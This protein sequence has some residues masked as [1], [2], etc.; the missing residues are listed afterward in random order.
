MDI[1]EELCIYYGQKLWF[2]PAGALTKI[3]VSEV[4]DGWGGL[5][6]VDLDG[7]VGASPTNPYVEGDQEDI[8]AEDDLP[9][10]RFKLPPEEEDADSIRTGMATSCNR[11]WPDLILCCPFEQWRLG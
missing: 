8:I 10:V 5:A 11:H 6:G 7:A 3:E 2:T 9:F 4:D 1:K